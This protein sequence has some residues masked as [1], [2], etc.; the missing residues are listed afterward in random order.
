MVKLRILGIL[1]L[2]AGVVC[3]YF[4][5]YITTQINEGK[6]KVE[7]GE[8]TIEQS[9]SLFS[10]NP[11]TKQ[12]GK[13]LSS[14]AQKKINAG[15]EEIAHYEQVAHML[16]VSGIAGIIVGAGLTIFSFFGSRKK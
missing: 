14:S 4:S 16:K 3:I 5:N 11:Y 13:G 2:L 1:I 7:K 8:K 9:N 12:V 6:V 10:L 15:K